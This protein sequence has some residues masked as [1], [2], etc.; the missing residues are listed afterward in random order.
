VTVPEITEFR[1]STTAASGRCQAR[2]RQRSARDGSDT[3]G[4][5]ASRAS[6]TRYG[7]AGGAI[8]G[9]ATSGLVLFVYSFF[10]FGNGARN[11]DGAL[12][13][14][15]LLSSVVGFPGSLAVLALLEWLPAPMPWLLVASVFAMP[16]LNW[17]GLGL[18]A[19]L[20]VDLGR[21]LGWRQR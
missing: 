5:S 18:L 16:L 10:A 11:P 7:A 14:A 1:P 3:S 17:L 19:G 15:L 20:V 21:S 2:F 12:A 8:V 6:A 4:V 9:L 13:G